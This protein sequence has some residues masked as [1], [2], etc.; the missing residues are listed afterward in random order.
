M[1]V[2]TSLNNYYDSRIFCPLKAWQPNDNGF[3]KIN[4]FINLLWNFLQACYFLLLS[5]LR[6]SLIWFAFQ[7]K[8][9][10][11]HT[12]RMTLWQIKM[13][14]L[15]ILIRH[16]QRTKHEGCW[17]RWFER[18]RKARTLFPCTTTVS[19]FLLVDVFYS[20][21]IKYSEIPLIIY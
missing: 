20:C 4:L 13:I 3:L 9:V 14:I 15:F 19:C 10:Q 18:T 1:F 6:V 7:I 16:N 8:I 2:H 17:W 21:W 12:D 5:T 11:I